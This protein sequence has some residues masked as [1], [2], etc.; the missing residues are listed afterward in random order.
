VVLGPDSSSRIIPFPYAK[1][2]I[3]REPDYIAVMDCPCR[4]ARDSCLP[5]NV[6][7][8][9]G[10]TTAS[11]WLEHGEKY[12]SRRI[13]QEEAIEILSQGRKK[14]NVLTAWF[15]VAT[16]GRTGVICSCCSCCCGGIE[17][18]RIIS[19]LKGAESISNIAPSG[20]S[21]RVFEDKCFSCGKCVEVCPFGASTVLPWEKPR[22]NSEKCLGCAVCA[23]LC[24]AG[25]REIFLDPEKGYPLD[26]DIA[27]QVIE[28][29]R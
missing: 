28:G 21:V 22:I 23:E 20:Y 13:S 29:T 9:V 14:G 4:L 15:K 6:C 11:F 16:G 10:K 8:A 18:M 25:A 26:L 1:S 27:R 17:G 12:H 5:I 2:I 7:I 19:K 3:L 24:Q